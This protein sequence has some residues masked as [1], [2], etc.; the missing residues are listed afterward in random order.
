M[1]I[2]DIDNP[3]LNNVPPVPILIVVALVLLG[4]GWNIGLVA[5][6]AL[7]VDGTDLADRAR[8]QGKVDV[9]IPRGGRGLIQS[10]VTNATV[11]VI[12]TGEGNVHVLVDASA[13][14]ET[15][16][17]LVVNSKT[18]R[19]STCNSAETLLLHSGAPETSREVLAALETS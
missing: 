2:S 6:T 17:R 12:E 19:T 13:A 8:V 5:G 3:A 1:P 10:V 4:V 7:V 16:T 15:A 14:A 18:H 11:P 9:L